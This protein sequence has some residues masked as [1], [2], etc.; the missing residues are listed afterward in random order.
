MTSEPPHLACQ[1]SGTRTVPGPTLAACPRLSREIGEQNG[2]S[3]LTTGAQGGMGRLT[4]E[5]LLDEGFSRIVMALRS[6]TRGKEAKQASSTTL[7][8]VPG[9]DMTGSAS[10]RAAVDT[11]PVDRPFDVVFLQSGGATFTKTFQ[12]ADT[13][14]PSVEL[15]IFQNV[16]GG[17]VT[18]ARL[19]EHGLLAPGAHVVIA[20]DEGARG[21]P[22]MISKPTYA[23]P[24]TCAPT[25]RSAPSL[26]RSTAR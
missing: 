3:I 19:N 21:L 16:T 10:I 18:L 7:E 26:T 9:F 5:G 23:T 6:E 12:A 1:E 24:A 13:D 17:H 15:T 11:L 2:R 25:S 20:G 8:V 14:G 22:P 4:T